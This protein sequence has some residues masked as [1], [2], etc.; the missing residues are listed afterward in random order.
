[1]SIPKRVFFFWGNEK[2]SWMRYL[3]L[4]S[5]KVLNPDWDV[6]L[7]TSKAKIQDKTWKDPNQQDFHTYSGKNYFDEVSN[8]D[9]EVLEWE[10]D[11][12]DMGPSHMSNFLKWFKLQAHGGIY[13]DMDILWIK[14]FD[15]IYEQMKESNTVICCTKYLS[16]G[17]LGSTIGNTFYHDLYENA[18]KVFTK[19]RYQ[20]VGVINIYRMIYGDDI[21]TDE[22]CVFWD[23]LAEQN[24]LED[25]Q[26][27]YPS[28][29]IYNIPMNTIY[30][31]PHDKMVQ[32]FKK[33]SPLPEETIGIHWYAG[34]K[35]GQ[36]YNCKLTPENI[37]NE[38][39]IFA[40]Y[41]CQYA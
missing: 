17:L 20:S 25:I 2:L 3:A 7:Y 9:V 30:P 18:K 12:P 24:I 33:I 6:I 16:I 22:G 5:F 39:S 1:M 15:S 11:L 10:P 31:F 28:L 14:P 19:D 4:K 38:I 35:I 23:N 27:K 34:S 26:K 40:K 8:L 32:V 29:S 41:A 37:H 21:M 36:E 13:A